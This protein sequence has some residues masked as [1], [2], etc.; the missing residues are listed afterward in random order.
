MMIVAL[1]AIVPTSY[2]VSVGC[3]RFEL[4]GMCGCML[5]SFVGC[6][7]HWPCHPSLLVELAR[8]MGKF[9]TVVV[10]S[11]ERSPLC[12]MWHVPDHHAFVFD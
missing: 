4:W 6:S 5:Y 2:W 9:K 10:M 12:M 11:K 3:D 7:T 1:M 8:V